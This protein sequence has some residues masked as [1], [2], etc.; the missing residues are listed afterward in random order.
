MQTT[1]KLSFYDPKNCPLYQYIIDGIKTV[2]GRKNSEQYQKIQKDDMILFEYRD[3]GRDKDSILC[4]V[5]YVNKYKDVKSYLETETLEKTLPCVKTINEGI[6]IY[7]SF[8]SKEQI[9]KLGFLGIGIEFIKTVKHNR[10]GGYYYK[11]YKKY[12]GRY[13]EE[14]NKRINVNDIIKDMQTNKKIYVSMFKNVTDVDQLL[15]VPSS[16]FMKKFC[17]D[18]TKKSSTKTYGQEDARYK[19]EARIRDLNTLLKDK[20]KPDFKYLDVGCNDGTLTNGIANH[21]G[22]NRDNVYGADIQFWSGKENDC[23]VN[24]MCFIDE[25]D[26]KLEVPDNFFDLITCYQVLHHN[27]NV[28]KMIAEI[29]RVLK[30]GGYLIIREHDKTGATTKEVLDMDHIRYLCIEEA[31]H[32]FKNYIGDYR[33]KEEWTELFG[34]EPVSGIGPFDGSPTR[35]Y[36][37]LY[38]K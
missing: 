28:C 36:T 22:F 4:K 1:H 33:S 35:I 21:F 29:K 38:I 26:P 6:K 27:K 32:S 18:V 10:L 19:I 34:M 30:V 13:V 17:A 25:D 12:A 9:E 15:K 20:I 16:Q 31:D 11:K 24:H 3:K 8:V 14:R 23:H 7:E 2:E 5:T 37:Y